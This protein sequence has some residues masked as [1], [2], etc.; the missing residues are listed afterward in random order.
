M[1]TYTTGDGDGDPAE[2]GSDDGECGDGVVQPG[3]DCDLGSQNSESGQCTPACT[4]AAC[5]DGY[6][7]EGFEECDDQNASNT[8]DCVQGC[9]LATC[10]DGF[11]HEGVETCD[12]GN[13]DPADGCNS[14]CLTGECGDG[15][16]QAGEQCDDGNMDTS[17]G[18]PACQV[19]FCGDGYVQA[20]VEACDDGN[21]QTN[22]GCISPMCVPATCG[23]GYLWEGMEECDDGNLSDADACPNSCVPGFCGDGFKW[24][25]MEECDDGN[26]IEDD[27]C[28]TSCI[29]AKDHVFLTSA[30]GDPGFHRYSIRDNMWATVASPPTTT[31]SH[32][33]NDGVS[34]FL[35][36]K[37]NTIYEYD[38]VDDSWSDFGVG[39]GNQ[40]AGAMGL[41]R[42]FPDGFYYLKDGTSTVYVRR[43]GQWSSFD[44]DGTGSS[45]GTYDADT[46]EL[47]IRTYS[48]LGFQVIDTTNDTVVRTIVD[49]TDVEEK[50]RNGSFVG[51]YFYSRTWY[52]PFQRF[53]G[54]TGAKTAMNGHPISSNTGTDTDF[55]TGK[56]YVSGYSFDGTVLQVYDPVNDMMTTLAAS[57]NAIWQSTITVM[58]H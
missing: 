32:I 13:D 22:D 26:K 54:V 35:M 48:Q 53:D 19:A 25:G 42:W 23:D 47:Y 41:F 46:R 37:N 9:K 1:S 5:G 49:D 27:S 15:V 45:A 3:E 4:I 8:D 11:T 31:N 51:G 44:L 38:P 58:R 33:T 2:T 29:A 57:P 39:P 52:G 17:D 20:G 30:D 50:N 16:L 18:C 6:V 21:D 34:V 10:G 12:D 56:I 40:T 7:Y 28:D 55:T 36:G 43:N 14:M 24:V